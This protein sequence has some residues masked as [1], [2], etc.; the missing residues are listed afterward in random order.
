MGYTDEDIEFAGRILT[1]REELEDDV[2]ARWMED[3]EHVQLLDEL[4]TFRGKISSDEYKRLETEEFARLV[5]SMADRKSRRMT[6]HWSVAASIIL[7]IALFISRALEEWHT[8]DEERCVAKTERTVPGMKAELILATGEKVTLQQ[9]SE[10][11]MGEKEFGI[12]NDSLTGLNYAAA[13]LRVETREELYNVLSIPIGGFYQ[14]T[15]ADGTKV[16][17]NSMTRLRY[18][19][20]FIGGERKVYLEGEAYFK[21]KHD[22][23]H[24]FIVA[25][26]GL[27]VKVYGTE[28]NVN[29]YKPDII[30]TVLVTG[31][32]G[33]TV[34]NTREEVFL[35]PDDMAEY[36]NLSDS[37]R[38]KKVDL[39]VYTAW[40]DG[41]FVFENETIEEIMK[42]LG[43]WYELKVFFENENAKNQIFSGIITRFTDVR[44]VL[45][46]IE[47]TATIKF[48]INGNVIIVR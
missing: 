23:V 12:C 37:L 32:V 1:E 3:K 26:G 6:L 46:L 11:I 30:Q 7:L 9:R 38:V 28:F 33:I 48:E 21:V 35:Q 2:V 10:M 20:N 43:R 36:F 40:K 13:N 44:D 17:L 5:Q 24:P 45:H 27:E 16:W 31:K 19:V 47:G 14:L 8:L 4:A 15:L 34:K 42:R 41:K 22:T 18:P 25:A 29:T 39:F